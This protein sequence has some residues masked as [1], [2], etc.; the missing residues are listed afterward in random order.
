MVIPLTARL[1]ARP[2][3]RTQGPGPPSDLPGSHRAGHPHSLPYLA[4][5]LAGF[6]K[7]P[8]SPGALVGSYPTVSPLPGP[9]TK[10]P[11]QAVC[12]LWHFPWGR[13][14]SRFGT[15]LPCG[16]R[17]FLPPF[18]GSDH[19]TRSEIKEL[20]TFFTAEPAENAEKYKNNLT[21]VKE[22]FFRLP[23]ALCDLA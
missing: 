2:A 8:R 22:P 18:P 19:L 21:C 1:P 16:A 4:L 7:L 20:K 13:P 17:T 10:P 3:A 14:L 15:A 23:L 9:E 6:T 11:A 5:L 12:F